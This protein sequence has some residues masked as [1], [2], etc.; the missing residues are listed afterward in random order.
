ML[1]M[2]EGVL[3][4]KEG[5]LGVA[6]TPICAKLYCPDVLLTA[7]INPTSVFRRHFSQ[8]GAGS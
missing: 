2:G 1:K 4:R 3:K 5:R 7:A 6:L 8:V